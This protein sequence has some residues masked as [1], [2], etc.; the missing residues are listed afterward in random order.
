MAV[1]IHERKRMEHDLQEANARLE[2]LATTD[3]LT[4]LPNRRQLVAAMDREI[5]RSERYGH[6]FSVILMDVDFFKSLNDSF[7]HDAGDG[8][9]RQIAAMLGEHSRTSD[10]AGR[11]GGEEFLVVCPETDMEGAAHL[12]ELFRSRIAHHDFNLPVLVT[13][14]FGIA[15]YRQGTDA[16]TLVKGA[17]D[18]LY[19]AKNDSRNCVRRADSLDRG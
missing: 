17:D 8:V 13:A 15:L 3:P 14:S 16:E 10:M 4:G 18:A 12:A 6:P 5:S 9:L 19:R 7:G 1:D 2:L 11:W